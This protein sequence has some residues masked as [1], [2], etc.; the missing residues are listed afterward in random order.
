MLHLL[1]SVECEVS[2]SFSG[3]VELNPHGHGQLGV[4][5]QAEGNDETGRAGL[6]IVGE[7]EIVVNLSK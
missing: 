6:G 4:A 3:S 1:N 5:V 7:V 2:S